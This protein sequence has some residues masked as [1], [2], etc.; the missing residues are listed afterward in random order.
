MAPS[1]P[2][3]TAGL[4]SSSGSSCSPGPVIVT[5][6]VVEAIGPALA[7]VIPSA[8][9]RWIWALVSVVTV[10]VSGAG[11]MLATAGAGSRAAEVRQ[12]TEPQ[13]RASW[14]APGQPRQLADSSTSGSKEQVSDAVAIA[15]P[16]TSRC[17]F[18]GRPFA[19]PY[20]LGGNL[21][22]CRLRRA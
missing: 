18:C 20:A 14:E 7:P 3:P 15:A 6:M 12:V 2:P 16:G 1:H 11:C 9:G 8:A 19:S 21:R 22:H 5:P 10:E 17:A 13:D 4:S